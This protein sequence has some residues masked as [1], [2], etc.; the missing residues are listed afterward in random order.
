MFD[1]NKKLIIVKGVKIPI[2]PDFRLMC[3][4]SSAVSRSDKRA[5]RDIAGRFFFAS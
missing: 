5:L 2:D 4:Y 1:R 3:E